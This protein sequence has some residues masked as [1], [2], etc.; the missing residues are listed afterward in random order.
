MNDKSNTFQC[1]GSQCSDALRYYKD[2]PEHLASRFSMRGTI[3][4]LRTLKSNTLYLSHPMVAYYFLETS[5]SNE[6]TSLRGWT[7][8]GYFGEYLG[9][10]IHAKI[11]K[12]IMPSGFHSMDK[13][14]QAL[15]FTRSGICIYYKR[16]LAM[17]LLR[18]KHN[19]SMNFQ[20]L[21]YLLFRIIQGNF[22]CIVK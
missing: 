9:D 11:F 18:F 22:L 6:T 1:D 17:K 10:G 8:T 16:F 3:N 2:L 19:L 12:K 14:L 5:Y 13:R 21:S 15:L 4:I 20:N 7:D